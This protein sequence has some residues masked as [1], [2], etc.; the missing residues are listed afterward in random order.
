MHKTSW[1]RVSKWYDAS[2]GKKGH[3]QH[4]HVIIPQTLKLM[5][6][7]DTDKLLDVGC[8]QGV[9]SRKVPSAIQYVGIDASSD[10]IQLAKK[11]NTM[12]RRLFAVADASRE[13][14]LP[15]RDFSHVLFMLSLQNMKDG[16]SAIRIASQ[17]LSAHGTMTIVL[18]HPAFR[19]PRQSAWG[20]DEQNKLQYRRINRYLSPLEIPITMHP[21]M[22][23]KSPVTWSYHTPLHTLV[24]WLRTAGL[25]ISHMEEWSS[26]RES[27]GKSAKMENRGRAEI[28]LFL[29]IRAVKY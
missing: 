20:I 14:P 6:L 21:G 22:G 23:T 8:G 24:T 28:P 11:R 1:Q 26:D 18:N 15:D 27:V 25:M 9:M 17:H 2:V 19:I 29:A 4:E 7:V 16:E 5:H 10:L 13:Y 12:P 3:Y